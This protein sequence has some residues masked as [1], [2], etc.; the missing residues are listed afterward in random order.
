MSLSFTELTA[1]Q[2]SFLDRVTRDLNRNHD[3]AQIAVYGDGTASPEGYKFAAVREGA[4]WRCVFDFNI[5]RCYHTAVQLPHDY[6]ADWKAKHR[7]N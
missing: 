1:S 2:I 7:Q 6:V 4:S 3:P 5:G